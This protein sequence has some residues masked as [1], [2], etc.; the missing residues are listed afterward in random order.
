MIRGIK[1]LCLAALVFLCGSCLSPS[2]ISIDSGQKE[3]NTETSAPNSEPEPTPEPESTPTVGF[4]E[5]GSDLDCF[6]NLLETCQESSLHYS[7]SL[8]FMGAEVSTTLQFVVTGP[9]MI[10]VSSL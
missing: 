6:Y 10:N 7:Q 2:V 9:W 3:A 8:D 4:T 5:C 1:I